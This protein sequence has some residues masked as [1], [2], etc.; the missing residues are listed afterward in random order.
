[1]DSR[2]RALVVALLA[3]LA[4]SA[5]AATLDSTPT[6]EG[7]SGVSDGDATGIGSDSSFSLGGLDP[8]DTSDA[9]DLFR[10]LLYLVLAIVAVAGLLGLYQFYEEY[11]FRGVV[12]VLLAGSVM[13]VF[14]YLV[15]AQSAGEFAQNGSGGIGSEGT[16]AL[17]GGGES[18]GDQQGVP[19]ADPPAAFGLLLVLAVVGAGLVLFRATGDEEAVPDPPTE[20]GSGDPEQLA[21]VAGE[22]ADRIVRGAVVDNEIYRAWREMTD[23]LDVPNPNASTPTEFAEAAVDAGLDPA[24]VAELTALFEAVRY[25]GADPSAERE[26]RAVDCLRRI[27]AQGSPRE[28]EEGAE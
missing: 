2:L 17:P 10:Y 19:T 21:R 11:G 25:G 26:R 3:V 6:G 13:L 7:G 28:G 1:M 15:F 23:L 18:G 16:P 22:A 4:L 5:A 8:A 12:V 27:E 20:S 14:I 9:S 24:D